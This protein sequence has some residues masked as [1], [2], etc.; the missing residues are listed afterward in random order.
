LFVDTAV[1]VHR[2][3]LLLV[4]FLVT[5]EDDIDDDNKPNHHDDDIGVPGITTTDDT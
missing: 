4:G 1:T 3:E 2:K 5:A